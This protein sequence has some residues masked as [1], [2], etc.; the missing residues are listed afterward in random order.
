MQSRGHRAEI[1]AN[2]DGIGDHE[3]AD[4]RVKQ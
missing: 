4:Q 2:I 3:Q 1:S